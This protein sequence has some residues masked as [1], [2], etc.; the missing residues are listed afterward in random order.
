MD[1]V[2]IL[3]LRPMETVKERPFKL[4][5]QDVRFVSDS[6][7]NF[8]KSTLASQNFLKDIIYFS[9]H[10]KD[11]INEETIELLE[12]YLTLRTPKDEEIF[13]P[14]VAKNTSGAL[15]GLCTWAAAMS[16]YHKQSKIVKPKLLL[17]EL[18]QNELQEAQEQL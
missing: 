16:D 17:L 11:N 2:H 6:F 5:K 13:V 9:E 8:C 7:D 3:F 1:A 15:V 18:K 10:E 12:P 4:L 14:A